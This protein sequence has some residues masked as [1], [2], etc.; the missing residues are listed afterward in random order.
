MGVYS[1]GFVFTT[2]LGHPCDPRNA[3]RA[4]QVPREAGLE[5]VGLHTLRH[6]GAAVA[7][8]NGTHLKVIS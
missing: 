1:R 4:L 6:T 7:I 3:L 8:A 5:G 2:E